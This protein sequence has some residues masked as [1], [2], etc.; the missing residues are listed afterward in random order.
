MKLRMLRESLRN[1]SELRHQCFN[2]PA[3][4]LLAKPFN[5]LANQLIPQTEREHDA[6]AEEIVIGSEQG[7]SKCVLGS[8]VH[9]IA[10]RPV[11]QARE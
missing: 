7:G 3:N 6:R 9:G 11:K 10:A 1:R 5:R 4:Q 8:R 2:F